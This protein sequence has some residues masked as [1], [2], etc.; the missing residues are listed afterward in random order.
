MKNFKNYKKLIK[1]KK[2]QY[3]LLTYKT[4]RSISVSYK[5]YMENP[6][7]TPVSAHTTAPAAASA[8]SGNE[9]ERNEK[10]SFHETC[11]RHSLRCVNILTILFTIFEQ[12]Y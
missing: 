12:E 8:D 2:W 9:L 1:K 4:Q 11:V 5:D 3:N 10:Y 7:T 6:A